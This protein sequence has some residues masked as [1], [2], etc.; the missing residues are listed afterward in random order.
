MSKHNA[1][2]GKYHRFLRNKRTVIAALA[3]GALTLGLALPLALA[4]PVG[5]ASGFE[6]DDGNL[7]VD[8]TFDWN[9]FSP[10]TWT[11]TA[12]NQTA[13]KLASGWTF[14]GLT[15]A[16]ATTSDSGYSGGVKQDVDC[17]GIKGSK[18]PNKDDLKRI[19]LATK[20]VN[21]HIYLNLAWMRIPQNTVN[22]SAHVGFEFNQGTT[23]CP[24]GSDGLVRRTAGDLLL[25]YDFEGSA[26]GAA[27]LTLRK[28]V[29][30]GAC[31]ISSDTAPCWGPATDL[32]ASGFAEAKVN[33]VAVTDTVAPTTDTLQQAEFGEAGVDLTNAGVFTPGVCTAFGQAEGVSRSSGNSGQAA[34]EDLVG[35][36]HISLANC[37]TINIIKHTDPR[38]INQNFSYTSNI[39][40]G[41]LNCTLDTTPASF[42]LN[43][44]AGVD[45]ASPITTG[46]D[47]TEHCANVPIGS[48][49]VTEGAEPSGFVLENLTCTA[50]GS[51][52]GSQDGTNP[53]QANITVAAGNETV[54][55]TYTNQQQLGAIKITKTSVKGNTPLAGATFSVTSGGTPIAGSPFTSDS[56]GTICVDHLAFGNYVV[57]ET[58]APS[59]Y[60]INDTT[61]HTVTVDNNALCSDATFVGE[62]I[63]FS[64]TPLTDITATAT[65]EA[66]G[67]TQST[68]TCVNSSNANVGNSPQG[69]G[70]SVSVGA[71]GLMPGTYTCTI[72]IDP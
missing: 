51:S 54:T 8:S 34:M 18:A 2:S 59:G 7:V 58:A 60:A 55:C 38:G 70:E 61:S 5:T 72:V 39:A 42:T 66:T 14:T 45:P 21:G 35:P 33:T 10:V 53:F 4:G 20:T 62:S 9:G 25:V 26:S 19:Y 23:A 22:A 65:S 71:N 47:N 32:T 29:T 50:T 37:G 44:H 3:A 52:S 15:D 6:D 46:T 48:Y 12:P 27:T 43:D 36:G 24:A 31:E 40:G 30:S 69:P 16:Q 56:T 57:T 63:S 68:I 41:Q 28:W 17:A 13:T 49:T 11:G 1:R 67:G 64:D